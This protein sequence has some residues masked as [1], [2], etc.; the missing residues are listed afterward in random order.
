MEEW[1]QNFGWKKVTALLIL[2]SLLGLI[3]VVFSM[4]QIN[5]Q[6]AK[7]KPLQNQQNENQN[8][9][10]SNSSNF[11][12]T[13]NTPSDFKKTNAKGFSFSYPENYKLSSPD[14]ASQS[15]IIDLK[16][17]QNVSIDLHSFP[18]SIPASS[19]V[20][21]YVDRGFE[22]DD[23]QSGDYTGKMYTGIL[24]TNPPTR[25]QFIV[26]TGDFVVFGAVLNYQS[27][28]QNVGIEKTFQEIVKTVRFSQN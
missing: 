7:D 16:G 19:V 21:N 11:Q 23:F 15:P 24:T 17:P 27:S 12:N 26:L 22:V 28:T 1:A 6:T 3:Y 2:A 13:S 14:N 9:G 5:K 25:T 8:G 4:F 10:Q 20:K 18:A